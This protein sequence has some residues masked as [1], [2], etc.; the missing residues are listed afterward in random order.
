VVGSAVVVVGSAVVVVG[1]AVVVVGS[2]VVVVGSTVVVVGATVV[3]VGSTVV[4]VRPNVVVVVV[5]VCGPCW[6]SAAV[7]GPGARSSPVMRITESTAVRALAGF[8]RLSPSS[9]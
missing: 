5:V 4:V 9:P 8:T 7:T 1:S 6:R 3:V 2:A